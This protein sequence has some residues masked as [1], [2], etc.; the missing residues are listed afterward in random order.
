[1][2]YFLDKPFFFQDQLWDLLP[3]L[4]SSA[5]DFEQNFPYLAEILGR[6]LL[7]QQDLRMIVLSSLRSALRY[8][9]RPDAIETRKVYYSFLYFFIRF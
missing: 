3:T 5:T 7:E 2:V 1:M 8:A 9:L 4:L 6:I